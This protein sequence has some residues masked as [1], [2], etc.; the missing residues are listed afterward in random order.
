VSSYK[1]YAEVPAYEQ[2][3]YENGMPVNQ[4]A[5][6]VLV[7]ASKEP[8]PAIGSV[9]RVSMN[10][11]G[12]GEVLG[13]FSEEKYLGLLVKLSDPPEWHRKQNNGNPVGHIF[14]PEWK[15]L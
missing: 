11:L 9:V 8:P 7:W 5:E 14:G 13:Y 1:E 3:V 2:A 4:P 6:G 12:N 15:P 10:N